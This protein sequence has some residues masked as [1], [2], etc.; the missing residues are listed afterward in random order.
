[1]KG[2]QFTAEEK[3]LIVESLLFSASC[4]VCSDH[5]NK[6]REQMVKLAEKIN[7]TN[8]K[9]YNIYIYETDLLDDKKITEKIIKNFSNLPLQ[10]VITD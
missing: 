8:Q 9:L 2:F 5:T 10:T 7:D 6:H 3:Q 4:D 1:M